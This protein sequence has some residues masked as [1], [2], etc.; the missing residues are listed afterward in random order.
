M[1]KLFESKKPNKKRLLLLQ[2]YRFI[3]AKG[4]LLLQ[5]VA[6]RRVCATSTQR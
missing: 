6:T 3:H 5:S 1:P 2:G 4:V